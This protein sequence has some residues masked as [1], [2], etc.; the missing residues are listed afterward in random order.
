M[1][2]VKQLRP[3]VLLLIAMSVLTGVAYPLVI[4]GVAQVVFSHQANGSLIERDGMIVGSEW[5]GQTFD[6]PKYFWGR[7]SAT[8]PACNAGASSG[9]NYGPLNPALKDAART[10]IE[11]LKKAD[12]QA[13][14]PVPVDLVTSSGS[15]LDPHISPAAVEYQVRRVA[16]LRGLP[17]NRVRQLV[18]DHT[19]PRTWGVL[20]EPCVNVLKLN[21]TLDAQPQQIETR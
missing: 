13:S 4:T 20:G 11:A 10:R 9:S 8:V 15:G 14:G 1:E 17:E 12:P 16:R 5:I 3:A 21:L 19:A 6:N 18:V 7:L 2:I